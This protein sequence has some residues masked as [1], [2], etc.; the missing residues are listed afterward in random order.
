MAKQLFLGGRFFLG[1]AYSGALAYFYVPG[2]SDPKDTYQDEML[3]V[4][5]TNPVVLDANGS[6]VVFLN[7]DYKVILKTASNATTIYTQDGGINIEAILEAGLYNLISNGTFELDS[8]GDGLPDDWT[9]TLFGQTTDNQLDD[10]KSY[11]GTKSLKCTSAGSGGSQWD[12]VIFNVTPAEAIE[13]A[14]SLE[15]S[16][17]DVRNVVEIRWFDVNGALL[18]AS[19][20]YDESAANPTTFTRQPSKAFTP[21]AS[22]RS[23]QIRAIG[24]HPSDPTTGSTWFD[25]FLVRRLTLQ[26]LLSQAG[27][28]VVATAAN[29]LARLGV[30]SEGSILSIEG[31]LPA[32]A[33]GLPPG[34]EA[35]YAGTTAPSGWYLEDGATKDA[36]TDEAL[37]DVLLPSIA[38]GWGYPS[39]L[40]N[41]TY[42]Q[43]SDVWT[44]SAHGKNNGAVVHL[45]NSG[46][47]L[48]GG[49]T[50]ET[51]YYVINKTTNTFQ[52]S[53][54]LG[55]APVGGLDSGSGTHSIY[56]TFL[57][58]D[59]RGRVAVGLDNMGGASANRVVAAS[60]DQVGGASGAETK[61]IA[62]TNLPAHNHPGSSVQGSGSDTQVGLQPNA[63]FSTLSNVVASQGSGTPF[64][65]MNPYLASNW[66]IKR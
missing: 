37:F 22:A 39:A 24:C 48:P 27:D 46:G 18:S 43:P 33:N 35:P 45:S 32:W 25:D 41:P 44:L 6:A 12:S 58:P 5:N 10:T 17:A 63:A 16:V 36:T 65:V 53:A 60:A 42:D 51:K 34:M 62:T 57:V 50:P 19:A 49:F 9:R 52:L 56:D 15:S 3:T 7:G 14:F 13:V 47:T 8:D 54:T 31:G 23:A 28:L 38:N 21:P 11:H 66:I 61:S 2:T 64:D 59:R 29:V 4:P 40:G 55:G 30:G 20:V 26:G 1:P